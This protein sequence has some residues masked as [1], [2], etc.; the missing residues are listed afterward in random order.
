MAS[1]GASERAGR[2]SGREDGT[3]RQEGRTEEWRVATDRVTQATSGVA[4]E[5][6][7]ARSLLSVTIFGDY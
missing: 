5:Q 2:L 3:R 6:I 7:E 1:D 4:P